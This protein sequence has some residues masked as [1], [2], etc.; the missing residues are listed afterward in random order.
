MRIKEMEGKKGKSRSKSKRVSTIVLV[1][2]AFAIFMVAPAIAGTVTYDYDDAGRLVKADY[3]T[4]TAIEYEYDNAGNLLEQKITGGEGPTPPAPTVIKP[5]GGEEIPG[6]SVYDIKWSVTKGTHDLAANPITIE[7]STNNGGSW[8]QIATDEANDGVFSWNVPNPNPS[9]SNCVVKVEAIDVQGNKG[10]DTSDSV[11]TVTKTSSSNTESVPAGGTKTVEGPAESNTTATVTTKPG[12]TVDVTVA[13]YDENPHP[14]ATKPAEMLDKYID[15]S[16]SDK[17]NVEWPMYVKM[18]YTDDEIPA[19][20]DE[21]TL[22]LYHYKDGAW[23]K[24]GSTGVNTDENYVWA[25]VTEDECAGSPF[26]S[27]GSSS[28]V[29]VPEFSVFGLLVLIVILTVVL[30]VYKL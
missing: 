12:K 18:N 19:G 26:C 10:D 29:P 2:F 7:Y 6:D 16:V 5:N 24:C 9:S 11:F 21:N 23:H 27:G 13:Y 28:P 17:E 4:G 22:G 25:Y 3:G 8:T 20:V 30:V 15:I 1:A 14:G